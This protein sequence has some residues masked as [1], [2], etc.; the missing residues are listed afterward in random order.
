MQHN[1][2]LAGAILAACILFVSSESVPDN[3]TPVGTRRE[4][5]YYDAY[6]GNGILFFID[7]MRTKL[8]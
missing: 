1:M 6:P 5:E 8:L 7:K 4:G 2:F 3:Y